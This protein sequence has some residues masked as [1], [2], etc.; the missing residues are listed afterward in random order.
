MTHTLEPKT[1]QP[2]GFSTSPTVSGKGLAVHVSLV[3]GDDLQELE[4]LHRPVSSSC[5]RAR[6]RAPICNVDHL[7]RGVSKSGKCKPPRRILPLPHGCHVPHRVVRAQCCSHT[8][9]ALR[10]KRPSLS[11][12]IG[13]RDAGSCFPLEG[14]SSAPPRRRTEPGP[15]GP[16]FF[17]RRAANRACPAKVGTGFA[18]RTCSNNWIERDDDSKKS[19]PALACEWRVTSRRM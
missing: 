9:L 15:Q 10:G 6:R 5:R 12:Q 13:G 16:G 17:C 19:H 1:A 4:G 7:W 14:V 8:C 3:T 11:S 18:K 2:K